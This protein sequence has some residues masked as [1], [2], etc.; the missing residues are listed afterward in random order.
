MKDFDN[1]DMQYQILKKKVKIEYF[2]I[3]LTLEDPEMQEFFNLKEILTF[4][5]N[6]ITYCFQST[7]T[8]NPGHN[9]LELYNILVQIRLTT[10]KRKLD[11]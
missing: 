3:S 2:A 6:I 1:Y 4:A 5:N 11:I 10:S 9:I 7:G 8:C